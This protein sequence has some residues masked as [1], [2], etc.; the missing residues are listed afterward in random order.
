MSD[1]IRTYPDAAAIARAAAEIL[2]ADAKAAIASRGRFILALSGGSTPKVL[3]ALLA[4]EYA[5]RIE[6]PKVAVFFGDERCVAADHADSN[7]KMA[8]ETL[9]SK[10]PAAVHRISGEYGP[11]VAADLY[12]GVLPKALP[13]FDVVLLGMGADGHT[14]SLFP[15]HHFAADAG[16][17]TTA[18]TAPAGFAIPDRVSLTLEALGSS[19]RAIAMITGKDKAD[20]LAQ[21]LAERKRGKPTFPMS[22][23]RPEG[24]EFLVD[25]AAGA[26]L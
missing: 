19:R 2:E 12:A 23:V 16:K 8:Q 4:S 1:L 24:V 22:M 6:W 3:Y 17:L 26:S 18:A 9:L 5:S 13:M 10:V 20:R 7:Y 14:A 11:R 21:I 15:G 25:T